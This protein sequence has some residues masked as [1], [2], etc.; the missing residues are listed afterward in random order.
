MAPQISRL[1]RWF[2]IGALAMVAIVAGAYYYAKWR[3]ENVLKQVGEKI[4]VEV[5]QSAQGFTISK[6]EAGRTLFKIQASKA[7]QYR[8]GGH[9]ELHDVN[10]ILYG[11]DSSRFDQIYGADFEYDPQS[12][13]VSAK[14]DV[15][16]DLQ[17]NPG[18]L[19]HPDQELP[20]ELKNPI[21][22][23]T[24]GLVFNQK[25]GD[26]YTHEKIEFRIPQAQGSAVGATYAAKTGVLTLQS[27]VV[28]EFHGSNPGKITAARAMVTKLPRVVTLQ[29]PRAESGT[30]KFE[31]DEVKFFLRPDNTL[32]RASASGKV[33]AES[34][35]KQ[36]GE[37]HAQQLEVAMSQAQ[38]AKSAA[39]SGGV[40]WLMAGGQP[41]QGHSDRMTLEFDGG[42][43]I[44]KVRSEGQ[45]VLSQRQSLASTPGATQDLNLTA[46]SL[47][48]FVGSDHHLQ[49]AA[50]SAG[51]I[52][53]ATSSPG[54]PNEETRATAG[55]FEAKFNPVGQ[56]QSLHG[57]PDARIESVTV[58]QPEKVSISDSLDVAFAEKGG[59][60][61][62][63]QNGHVSYTDGG[64]KAWGERA[65]FG[66]SDQ[67]LA[68]SGAPR[69]VSGGMTTTA[70]TV[71]FSRTSGEITAQGNVKSTYSDLKPQPNGA[72]LATGDP[73]HVTA[74]AVTANRSSAVALY[75][76]GAR[77][78][79]QA[80]VIEAPG[81]DFD[82]DHRSV[83]A[84]SS[85]SQKVSTTLIQTD[86][87]GG[88]IPLTILSGRLT[89]I[90][91]DA[92][93]HFG[94]G[95]VGKVLDMTLTATQMDAFRQGAGA[96]GNSTA[97]SPKIDRIVAQGQVSITQPGRRA[98]GD[99]L[100]YTSVDDKFVLTGGS[101]S[102]FDAERGKITGVSLTF[103]RH[104]AR[105]LVEG[106]SASPAVTQT[107]VAR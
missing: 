81:I 82:R 66:A 20:K 83:V 22:L 6:S 40:R 45:V 84:H 64:L 102:I 25:S 5:Q 76:G 31:S 101:P 48:L 91:N 100:T 19:A 27:E 24:S 98:T 99:R 12:G 52:V 68:M 47:D 104:D 50:A 13:N 17:A 10:I 62:L 56:L 15:Q 65:R 39:F 28:A 36:P 60:A 67:T 21:H 35:G 16:I 18:G 32:E 33:F 74:K 63:E 11:D 51:K 70:D 106:N 58:G 8:A 30:E 97:G 79:Q 94:D 95:V 44:R 61:S 7:V 92:K 85:G 53:I 78:W 96:A 59:V 72:L 77:L 107:R 73:I 41:L 87:K 55:K 69:L 57:T 80:N 2:G 43:A 46:P 71:T 34:K 4:G 105:V 1:R 3:V 75:T 42:N 86:S 9:S 38:T 93:V 54:K 26:A 23:K 89:Y 37:V 14:G 29:Q 90:D 88:V 49:R 103:F